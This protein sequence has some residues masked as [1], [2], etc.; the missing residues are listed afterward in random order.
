MNFLLVLSLIVLSGTA[1]QAKKSKA[2]VH[3]AAKL[4][5]ALEANHSG[6]MILEGAGEALVGFEAKPKNMKQEQALMTAQENLKTK[7][8]EMV[9]LPAAS[10]C[11]ITQKSFD[12]V[13]DGHHSDFKSVYAI[14]C[15]AGF[16]GEIAF[17]FAKVFPRM[18]KVSA[19]LITDQHQKQVEVPAAG[20]KLDL[21]K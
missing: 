18:K 11:V 14:Q 4:V 17:Q 20:A 1:A 7:I 19:E 10:K 5:L 8:S 9:V 13:Y 2:H 21:S 12:M 16:S 6:E 3:G 15:Q